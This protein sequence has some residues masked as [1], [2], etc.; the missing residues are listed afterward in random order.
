MT[1]SRANNRLLKSAR[2]SSILPEEYHERTFSCFFIFP[3][4]PNNR[5]L[6]ATAD[7]SKNGSAMDYERCCSDRDKAA[8]PEQE[9]SCQISFAVNFSH[10]PSTSERRRHLD[11][12]GNKLVRVGIFVALLHH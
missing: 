1:P 9:L 5:H 6:E 8:H 4:S 2:K 3:K 11:H 10:R 7:R 12:V